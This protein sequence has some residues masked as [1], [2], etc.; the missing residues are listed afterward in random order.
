MFMLSALRRLNVLDQLVRDGKWRGGSMGSLRIHEIW[1]QTVGIVGMGRIGQNIA[2]RL[3][4]FEPGEIVYCDPIRPSAE[5]ERDL[6]IRYLSLEEL[7]KTAD[8]VT[9]HVPLMPE[10]P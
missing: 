8:I 2:Q 5:R 10:T 3:R 7:L 6:G 4:P 9:L 1:S